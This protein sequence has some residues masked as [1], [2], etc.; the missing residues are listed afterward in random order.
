MS[1]HN[2]E[3]LALLRK[4]WASWCLGNTGSLVPNQ[5]FKTMVLLYYKQFGKFKELL[6]FFSKEA[7]SILV[8]A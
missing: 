7:I 2:T 5:L 3:C 6:F 8:G 4:L 1:W